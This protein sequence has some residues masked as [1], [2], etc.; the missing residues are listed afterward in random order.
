MYNISN[1]VLAGRSFFRLSTFSGS[2]NL[3]GP[4]VDC[5]GPFTQNLAFCSM[6]GGGA[7]LLT[8]AFYFILWFLPDFTCPL[9]LQ[10]KP[11]S[12]SFSLWSQV[13]LIFDPYN[14]RG[15]FLCDD[16]EFFSF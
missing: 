9:F 11:R 14:E 4:R 12:L 1:T 13:I 8:L 10:T 16:L 3:T 2:V 5:Q 6:N 7:N 15:F